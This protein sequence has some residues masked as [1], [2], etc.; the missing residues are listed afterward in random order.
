VIK[1]IFIGSFHDDPS[2]KERL[3]HS[4]RNL[5]GVYNG[6]P[7]FIA[8]EYAQATHAALVPK[9]AALAESLKTELPK[10]GKGFITNF[11]D[12][13][14]YEGDFCQKIGPPTQRVWMLDGRRND[15]IRI[16]DRDLV[17]NAL[18]LKKINLR[19]W[20]LPKI[21]DLSRLSDS[22]ILAEAASVNMRE[23]KRLAGLSGSAAMREMDVNKSIQSGRE[24]HMFESLKPSLTKSSMGNHSVIIIGAGHL[25]D[26]P[27][28]LF[29][30]CCAL[31]LP[32]E[33]I[34]PHE[35]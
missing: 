9:R 30:S 21:P 14:A 6:P 1:I 26:V 8:V 28:S 23:S 15:D 7:D 24:A 31:E 3:H 5:R 10:I 20:L 33:R 11:A 22:K 29:V 18:F 35:Q 27:G 13:L 4:L 32:V 12:T 19:D 2:G 34:W 25:L 16:T 17:A